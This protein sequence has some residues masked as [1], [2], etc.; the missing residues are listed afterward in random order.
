MIALNEFW[1]LLEGV[2][3][4]WSELIT[5]TVLATSVFQSQLYVVVFLKKLLLAFLEKII[6]PLA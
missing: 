6:S 2:L 4:L 5:F 3:F 1:K